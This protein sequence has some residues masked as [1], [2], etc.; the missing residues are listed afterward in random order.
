MH[1]DEIA[2]AIFKLRESK[3]HEILN[4]P[5]QSFEDF[6]ERKGIWMGLGEALGV[7]EDARKKELNDDD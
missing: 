5:P 7:I 1:I 3:E 4:T 2:V 6:K